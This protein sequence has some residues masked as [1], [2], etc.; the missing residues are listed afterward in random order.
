MFE[1]T[2][3]SQTTRVVLRFGLIYGRGILMVEAA[4]W[5]IRAAAALCELGAGIAGTPFDLLI[6]CRIS[7]LDC[8][9]AFTSS[10]TE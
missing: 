2:E 8:A 10:E 4:R 6:F 7:A 5:L 3:C 9:H 1:R